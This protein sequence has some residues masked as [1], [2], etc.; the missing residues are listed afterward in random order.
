MKYSKT[1]HFEIFPN[2]TFGVF[3]LIF[4]DKKNH[5]LEIYNS[6]GSLIHVVKDQIGSSVID[7]TSFS[8]G[9]YTIR[10]MPDNVT[11]QIVKQ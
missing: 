4:N 11:Y 6:E 7:L 5:L 10:L 2:P 1:P 8:S 9:T 3:N